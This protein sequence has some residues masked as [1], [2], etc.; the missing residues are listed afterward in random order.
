MMCLGMSSEHRLWLMGDSNRV[1][2]SS[3]CWDLG[4]SNDWRR[5]SH[6]LSASEDSKVWGERWL[7]NVRCRRA[8]G[9][10]LWLRKEMSNRNHR[11]SSESITR[12]H[13]PWK[14]RFTGNTG[15]R[16]VLCSESST[17]SHLPMVHGLV[18]TELKTVFTHNLANDKLRIIVYH[19][20]LEFLTTRFTVCRVFNKV[21]T[22]P[23]KPPYP[24]IL[25]L[26]KTTLFTHQ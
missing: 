6:V 9:H 11:D 10:D 24:T 26:L 23:P 16:H 25:E 19:L 5:R 12:N 15:I 21:S 14:L 3:S 1:S 18:L 20:Q 4:Y 2:G 13:P 7:G 17:R 22:N 8:R